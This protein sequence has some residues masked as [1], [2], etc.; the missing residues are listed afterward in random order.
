MEFLGA[1]VRARLRP[2]AAPDLTIRADL[3]ANLVRRIGATEGR[4]LAVMVPPDLVRVFPH[5]DGAGHG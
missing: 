2:E 4:R 1:F 3:S 5:G